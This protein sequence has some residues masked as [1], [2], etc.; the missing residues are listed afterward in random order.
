MIT[1]F[2]IE[3]LQERSTVQVPGLGTFTSQ[4]LS[5][6]VDED[7][8]IINPP[9]AEIVF[10]DDVNYGDSDD[11][12]V[13]YIARKSDKTQDEIE[14]EIERLTEEI[15]TAVDSNESYRLEGLGTFEKG[16]YGNTTFKNDPDGFV[17]SSYG[18]PK[19]TLEPLGEDVLAA[20]DQDEEV[21][22]GNKFPEATLWGI[23]IPSV[24]IVLVA[25]WL[26][27]DEGARNKATA[28]ISGE[29]VAQV[30]ANETEQQNSSNDDSGVAA[31]DTEGS[32]ADEAENQV[33]ENEATTEENTVA[34]DSGQAQETA[35]NETENTSTKEETP[36]ST[37]NNAST[38]TLINTRSGRYY[39]S[40]ASYPNRADALARRE[41]LVNQ[42]YT[43]AKVVEAGANK[44]RV[45]LADFA[46]RAEA[47]Q[48][49]AE[50]KGDYDSIWVFKF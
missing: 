13:T 4:P 18:L 9:S 27:I 7:S 23:L 16:L 35:S 47:N 29:E 15:K 24:L 31:N 39:L 14:S 37:N 11:S 48:K 36:Q 44:F 21:E 42:G 43:E 28:L 34:E 8:N 38:E 19:L 41:Q 40:I 12:I 26:M 45:S 3:A 33:A 50:A 20:N 2:L 17:G 10:I 6:S 22:E 30:D 1:D 32:E 49:V 5:A 25:V 46:S